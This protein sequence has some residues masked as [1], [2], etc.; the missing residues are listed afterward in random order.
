MHQLT[1]CS[2]FHTH[3]QTDSLTSRIALHSLISSFA[4]STASDSTLS[5]IPRI[6]SALYALLLL[7]V[8][9]N[10]LPPSHILNSSSSLSRNSAAIHQEH[11]VY[12]R[13]ALFSEEQLTPDEMDT[14]LVNCVEYLGTG[15]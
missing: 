3:H 12:G 7:L 8:L 14:G 4:M 10:H 15:A 9:L 1:L 13:V 2:L 5:L 11:E 6:V